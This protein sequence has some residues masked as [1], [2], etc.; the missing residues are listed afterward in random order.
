MVSV[1]AV[2]PDVLAAFRERFECYNRHDFDAMEA[3]YHPDA[4]F[5]PSR[6]FPGERPRRGYADM[7]PYWEEMWEIWDGIQ[8]NP[9]EV[10]DV[11]GDRYVVV[12]EFGL[13]G[14]RSGADVAQPMA[15]L[16][17][18]RDDLVARAD[19]FAD[20]E[21]ALAAAAGADG[22]RAEFP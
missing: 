22:Q 21:T 14:K 5:D 12:V 11:G 8:M 10:L 20:R 2:G 3:M 15:F 9:V 6:V 13:R 16:Y 19:L 17:T 7:R 1:Q 18:V 4:V